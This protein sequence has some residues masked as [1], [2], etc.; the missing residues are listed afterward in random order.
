MIK[1]Q[2]DKRIRQIETD[3]IIK[4]RTGILTRREA[5]QILDKRLKSIGY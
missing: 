1:V 4:I 2:Q 3:L 5:A